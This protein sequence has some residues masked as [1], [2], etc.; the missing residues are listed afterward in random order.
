VATAV[1][2]ATVAATATLAARVASRPG[3]K[4]H[5]RSKGPHFPYGM[6]SFP[7]DTLSQ[8]SFFQYIRSFAWRPLF[9]FTFRDK[10]ARNERV[11]SDIIP[12][13]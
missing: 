1:A 3:G 8:A 9:I 5:L 6:F 13:L 10:H 12:G 11:D 4:H 2:V 7:L